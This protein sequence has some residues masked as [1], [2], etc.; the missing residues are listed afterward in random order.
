MS[1]Q[2]PTCLNQDC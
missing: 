1:K 2:K